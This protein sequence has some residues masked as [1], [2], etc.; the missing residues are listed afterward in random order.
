MNRYIY[1]GV[2]CLFL[3][4]TLF[5]MFEVVMRYFFNRPTIWA[6]DINIQLFSAVVVLGSAHTLKQSG[7]V[8]MDIFVNRLRQR[9]RLI[10]N[11]AVYIVFFIAMGIAIW[12][13]A[14]FAWQ[15][16][17]LQEEASTFFAPP[18]YPIKTGILIGVSVLF[19]QG[20]SLFIRD[21]IA[22]RMLSKERGST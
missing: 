13:V 11:M 10:V 7:H 8:I 22:Y 9:T 6:W 2:S 1:N 5:A 19:L 20:I 14:I 17:L 16:I 4:M 3:P 18:V 21:L 15:S 12:Q